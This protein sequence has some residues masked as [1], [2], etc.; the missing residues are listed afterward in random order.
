[1]KNGTVEVRSEN[2]TDVITNQGMVL[3]IEFRPNDVNKFKELLLLHKRAI[4]TIFYASGT[5]EKKKWNA[6]NIT[7]KS[8]IIRNLRSRVEFRQGNWQ[9]A[10]VNSIKVEIVERIER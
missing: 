6:F 1:M 3:P 10:N 2:N 5:K 8:D 9:D 4:I 7:E